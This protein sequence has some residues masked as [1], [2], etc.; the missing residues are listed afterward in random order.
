MAQA[1]SQN[2][3]AA[4]VDQTRRRFLTQAA[5]VAAGG[6]ALALAIPPAWA[7]PAADPVFAA[8]EVHRTAIANVRAA[9]AEP[10]LPD[11][12]FSEAVSAECEAV[13]R[14]VEVA[15]T[16]LQGLLAVLVHLAGARIGDHE[17][18]V[19]QHIEPLIANLGE[20]AAR[21]VNGVGK[22]GQA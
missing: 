6:T 20:A 4:P 2:T 12:L 16:T 15:P 21:F 5:G 22:A 1:D 13:D 18:I 7:S 19:E 11:D 3:T 17:V 8:I 10:D 9:D 14:L